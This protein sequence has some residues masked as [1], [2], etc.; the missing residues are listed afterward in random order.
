M[1]IS[2]NITDILSGTRLFRSLSDEHRRTLVAAATIRRVEAVAD[3]VLYRPGD[4]SDAV[5]LIVDVDDGI[6]PAIQV[7]LGEA[8]SAGFGLVEGELVGDIELLKAGMA[9]KPGKRVSSARILRNARL[10]AIRM[11]ALASVAAADPELRRRLISQA[12]ERLIGMTTS[13]AQR[14]TL[15]P[16]VRFARG[17]LAMLDDYGHVVGNKGVFDRRIGQE[18]LRQHFN[19]SLRWVSQRLSDWSPRGLVDTVPIA[20]PDFARVERIAELAPPNLASKLEAALEV[21]D[22][23]IAAAMLV[24]AGQTAADLLSL[25]PG[26]PVAAFQLALVSARCGATEQSAAILSHAGLAWTGSIADLKR[27]VRDAWRSS[28]GLTANEEDQDESDG[29]SNA[30]D[31]LLD[32]RLATLCVD[33]GA[34]HA[35]LRKAE[36]ETASNPAAA[37]KI[38]ANAAQLYREVGEA[39]PNHYCAVNAAT[40]ALIAGD[41]ALAGQMASQALRL[42]VRDRGYWATASM[43][44]AS[45]VQG[46]RDKAAELFEQAAGMDDADPGKLASTRKQLKLAAEVGGLDVSR[47]LAILNPGHALCF[48]GH[49]M[50]PS[51]GS[52]DELAAAEMELASSLSDWLADRRIASVHMSLACGADIIFAELVLGAG[53]PLHITLPFPAAAFSRTSVEIGNGRN[54]HTD[55]TRRYFA[56]LDS[57]A[58]ITELWRHDVKQAD[59]SPHFASANRHIMGATLKQAELLATQPMMLAAIA[60]EKGGRASFA[61]TTLDQF[62]ARGVLVDTVGWPLHRPRSAAP[63]REAFDPFAHVVFAFAR[64]VAHNEAARTVFERHGLTLRT[65]KDRRVA[66]HFVAASPGEASVRAAAVA[67][68]GASSSGD[69]R[70]ICDYG[71]VRGRSGAVLLDELLK[72]EASTDLKP[73]AVG[74]V[75]ATSAFAMDAIARGERPARYAPMGVGEGDGG[76]RGA[77]EVYLLR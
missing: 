16:Q 11:E 38:A 14:Q 7:Q 33:I 55:W 74:S 28:F 2:T 57:A 52:R 35:R 53:I 43:A 72:L 25:L 62:V 51:D 45:L 37:R 32:K 31:A 6:G 8:A 50:R 54:S 24:K 76:L 13:Q 39:N 27:R 17:L 34:L 41:E 75:F 56:C 29:A 23:Q 47:G 21:L 18:D 46:D 5:F 65:L 48:S 1:T 71:P 67:P 15:D 42:A 12:A 26:N 19:Q 70:A 30:L 4:P 77:R 49:I 60:T 44:E 68:G 59:L 58:T 20:L 69:V 22:A 10:L 61:A 63:E 36:I 73:L 3:G 64:S 66:G 40:L 9:G